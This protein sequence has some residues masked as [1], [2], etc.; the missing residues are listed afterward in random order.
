MILLYSWNWLEACFIADTFW[1]RIENKCEGIAPAH[2]R[3]NCGMDIAILG[4]Q[5]SLWRLLV[6]QELVL[7]CI[8]FLCDCFCGKS[9]E[10]CNSDEAAA[11]AQCSLYV[12]FRF[13]L[14]T[15]SEWKIPNC[16]IENQTKERPKVADWELCQKVNNNTQ[17]SRNT[18]TK[19]IPIY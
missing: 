17:C 14:P 18:D 11:A 13:L 12:T 8:L 3:V 6:T 19:T 4:T 16:L 9:V 2:G 10:E 7:R 15:K 5:G 1:T